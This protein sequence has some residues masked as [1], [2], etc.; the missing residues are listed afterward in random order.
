MAT[1]PKIGSV[2]PVTGE[3]AYPTETLLGKPYAREFNDPAPAVVH[4]LPNGQ[5][6]IGEV[7]YPRDFDVNAALAALR[8]EPKVLT[9]VDNSTGETV[10]VPA[11]TPDAAVETVKKAK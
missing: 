3:I 8:G 10:I 11:V 4:N 9:A 5:F 6:V 1:N 7:F 2:N